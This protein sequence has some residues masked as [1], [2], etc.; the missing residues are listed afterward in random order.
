MTQIPERSAHTRMIFM[1][2][3][4]LTD[5]FRL[6]G[7]ETRAD[8][9]PQEVEKLLRELVNKRQNAFLV[10]DQTLAD[11]DMPMLDRVRAEGGHIVVVTVPPLNDADQF[12]TRIDKRLQMMLGGIGQ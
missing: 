7:F 10:L 3:A 1:G 5:G 12:S 2:S 9:K 8:P 11:A 6:I 4:A